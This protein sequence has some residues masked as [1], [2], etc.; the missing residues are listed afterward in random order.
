[1]LD[2]LRPFLQH[3]LFFCFNN[4][5]NL[6]F[7]LCW[8]FIATQTFLYLQQAGSTLHWIA[9]ASYCSGLFYCGP[10]ARGHWVSVVVAH[11]LNSCSS[12]V[13]EHRLSSCGQWTEL[14]R[15]I[16]DLPGSGIELESTA[17]LG[18]FFTTEPPG[19]P[20]TSPFLSH[21]FL[22]YF[23][24]TNCALSPQKKLTL[25]SYPQYLRT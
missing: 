13:L 2:S 21:K 10:Q 11:G 15:G 22:Q 25:T 24:G 18:R 12:L 4:F 9:Q 14:L 6:F 23:Y 3:H 17:L 16:W 7:W 8:V 20:L 19:K 1:M 5:K